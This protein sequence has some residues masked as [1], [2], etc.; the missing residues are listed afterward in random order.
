VE[1]GGGA[2]GWGLG[3]TEIEGNV[4]NCSAAVAVGASATRELKDAPPT[5]ASNGKPAIKRAGIRSE[6][7]TNQP[8]LF[9]GPGA[10]FFDEVI[11]KTS[12]GNQATSQPAQFSSV[13]FSSSVQVETREH[14][15]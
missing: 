6:S 4:S 8:N 11:T 9:L 1:G 3:R 14:M 13:Q 5:N 15:Q 7:W 2:K 12:S 10:R